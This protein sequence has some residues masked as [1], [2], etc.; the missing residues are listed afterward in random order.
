[1]KE[2]LENAIVIS[3]NNNISEIKDLADSLG[4]NVISSFIQH[5]ENPDVNS[6]IGKGKVDEIKKYLEDSEKKINLIIVD[7]EL[8]P[9]QWFNLEKKFEIDV[10]DRIRLILAIFEKRAEKKE[11]KLQVKLAQLQYERPFVRELIHRAKSGEHPGFLAGA[12]G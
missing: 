4:Y 6:Y 9:S 2:S 10:Y 11:A 5:R 1:M 12:G 7:G 3:L 8:K